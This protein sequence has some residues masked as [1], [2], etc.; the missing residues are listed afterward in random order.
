MSVATKKLGC[1]NLKTLVEESKL[2][3]EDYNIVQE[4][5]TFMQKNNTCQAEEGCNDD[6]AMCL[7]IFSWVV[8]Q[9]YFKEM[10]DND[11]RKEI[12]NEKENQI[13]QDMSP[14]GFFSDG[15]EEGTF[16]DRSG[17]VWHT[18]EYGDMSHMWEYL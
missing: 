3:F 15:T 1:S 8:A 16:V 2:I 9:D 6:L 4:L 14:F 5:T 10:T 11:V 12:Y 17:D 18:D 13:E 7:V